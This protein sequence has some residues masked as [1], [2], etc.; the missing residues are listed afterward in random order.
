MESYSKKK[1]LKDI[2][3]ITKPKKKE[4]KKDDKNKFSEY[5]Q[6]N[7]ELDQDSLPN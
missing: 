7:F 2:L 4:D 1:S 5:Q 3:F 6:K